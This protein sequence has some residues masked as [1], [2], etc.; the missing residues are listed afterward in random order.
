[1]ANL[2]ELFIRINGV[3]YPL[4]GC[5]IVFEL[6][7]VPLKEDGE[8]EQEISR[9]LNRA[10]PDG[11]AADPIFEYYWEDMYPVE[12]PCLKSVQFVPD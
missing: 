7:R 5:K 11:L 1:M 2:N 3:S 10:L 12:Y 6:G 4:T 9:K 8:V